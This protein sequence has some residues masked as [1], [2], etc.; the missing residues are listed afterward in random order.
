MSADE[1]TRGDAAMFLR[2]RLEAE[3]PSL[4]ADGVSRDELLAL[5]RG[6]N[7]DGLLTEAEVVAAVDKAARI[8]SSCL[9][10]PAS[11]HRQVA[12][13]D[14]ALGVRHI[15]FRRGLRLVHVVRFGETT[16][17][18]NVHRHADQAVAVGCS[19]TMVRLLAG[20][21]GL[22]FLRM[23]KKTQEL[24]P[25]DCPMDAAQAFV[26]THGWRNVARLDGISTWPLL[27]A[28][29]TLAVE[30]GYDAA[31]AFYVDVP[32]DLRASMSDLRPLSRDE[33]RAA[34]DA[35]FAEYFCDV[36]FATDD[37]RAAFLA[38]LL[39][40]MARA[41]CGNVPLF[42]F[43]APQVGSGKTYTAQTIG[44][45]YTGAPPPANP[46]SA[47]EEEQRKTLLSLLM[48]ADGL[49]LFDNVR[50][51]IG[52][53]TLA[54]I[55]TS[56]MFRDRRLG[57]NDTESVAASTMFMF[58]SNNA[59]LQVD[60]LRRSVKVRLDT[61]QENPI[62]RQFR[63]ADLHALLRERRGAVL[64]TLA[65]LLLS[66]AAAGEQADSGK[67]FP[68]FSAWARWCRDPVQWIGYG[69]AA[70]RSVEEAV[71]ADPE[72][73]ALHELLQQLEAGFG[74]GVAFSTAQIFAKIESDFDKW[75][76]PL[77]SALLDLVPRREP[78]LSKQRV[79]HLL[80]GRKDRIA[81]SFVLRSRGDP[82]RGLLFWVERVGE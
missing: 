56:G 78:S 55:A 49:V 41:L 12:Y 53:E 68:S 75:H 46:W 9:V 64:R 16:L 77:G 58:T 42:I 38:A 61:R 57:T 65:T 1:L 80:S 33:C 32:P 24:V 54:A 79:G 8:P 81:R 60:L 10:E 39:T 11:L 82:K 3:L 17:R 51:H 7:A 76:G 37:D 15:V 67:T 6:W 34:V 74:A 19:A 29:G 28:D 44:V 31:T 59:T 73:D 22:C 63:H 47:E 52:G 18:D 48:A 45:V 14:R 25:V 36:P 50:G 20:Q 2:L 23:K 5:A 40:P 43:D 35:L 30:S 26:Q 71:Q 13:L 21:H 69:D 62:S 70:R 4:A 27:R 66:R 72:L